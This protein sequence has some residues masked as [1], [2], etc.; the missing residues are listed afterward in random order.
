MEK[1]L[2]LAQE[3]LDNIHRWFQCNLLTV[4]ISKTSYIIFKSKNKKIN[5]HVGLS[6]NNTKLKHSSEEK[7]LGLILDSNLTWKP[8]ITKIRSKLSSLLGTLRGIV[9]CLPRQIRYN[10]YNSLVKSHLDHLI[11]IWGHAAKTTLKDLQVI[12]NK[13]IKVLFHYDFLTP[14][15]KYIQKLR[16]YLLTKY[17]T[18]I[19]VC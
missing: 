12:Q 15:K 13:I 1:K 5:N 7:Y 3:D 6:I 8:H 16:S 18:L 14:T 11:E 9:K 10:I 2:A 17:I 4:N 19:H